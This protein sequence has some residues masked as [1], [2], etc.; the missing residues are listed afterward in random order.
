MR[1]FCVRFK[2]RQRSVRGSPPPFRSTPAVA[3]APMRLSTIS[4]S[5][6]PAACRIR[7]AISSVSASASTTSSTPGPAPL[8]ATPSTPGSPARGS[9]RASSGQASIRY[10][11][12]I[13]SC[14]ATCSRSP[15]PSANAA[16]SRRGPLHVG[17]RIGPAVLGGQHRPR[18]LGRQAHRRKRQQQLP[19]QALAAG[20]RGHPSICNHRH[21]HMSQRAGRHIV[22]MALP[23]RGLL[24]ARAQAP[25]QPAKVVRQHH[26][27]QPRRRARSA[28]HAQRN[29]VVDAQIKRQQSPSRTL[30]APRDRSRRSGCSGCARSAPHRARSPQSSVQ[31]RLQSSR[32]LP[33]TP[34]P[35]SSARSTTPLRPHRS[36]APGS[37][38]WQAAAAGFRAVV[39][40]VF[41]PVMP[42]KFRPSLSLILNFRASPARPP[43][44]L[45][46]CALPAPSAPLP[47]PLPAP[48]GGL[49]S[50]ACR[51]RSPSVAPA[52]SAAVSNSP[53]W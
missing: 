45:P 4:S 27:A 50:A 21:R 51:A 52:I 29:L 28:S 46:P 6:S 1:E 19:P 37:R 25:T 23:S 18:L 26:S 38:W 43:H 8:S 41:S 2:S 49:R 22:G 34:S 53:R 24:D 12:C 30:S 42:P 35:Q 39:Q 15:R 32:P 16:T 11:W 9:S 31:G 7:A 3:P 20:G 5:G 44:W 33:A 17:H 48:C 13:R 36:P 47:H 14:I 10:G 40:P